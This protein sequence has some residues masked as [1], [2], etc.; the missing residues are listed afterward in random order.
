MG[1]NGCLWKILSGQQMAHAGRDTRHPSLPNKLYIRNSILY[2]C[3]QF[4]KKDTIFDPCIIGLPAIDLR[5]I[6]LVSTPV[7]SDYLLSIC[8]KYYES[9]PL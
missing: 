8:E 3:Y 9:R 2:T 5:K 6:I 4:V 1:T 7:L